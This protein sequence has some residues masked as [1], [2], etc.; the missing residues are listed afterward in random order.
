MLG[1]GDQ[2]RDRRHVAIED[3]EAARQPNADHPQGCQN[4]PS[5]AW[6]DGF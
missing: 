1:I 3:A 2:S 6:N 4:R 5:L